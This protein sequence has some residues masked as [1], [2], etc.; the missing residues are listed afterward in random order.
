MFHFVAGEMHIQFKARNVLDAF[1][2]FQIYAGKK[3]IAADYRAFPIESYD[4]AGNLIGKRTW[5]EWRDEVLK[6]TYGENWNDQIEHAAD[7]M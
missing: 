2:A 5:N 7:L 1:L 6:D 3:P 4:D